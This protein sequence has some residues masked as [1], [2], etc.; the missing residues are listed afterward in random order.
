MKRLACLFAFLLLCSSCDESPLA[1]G[2]VLEYRIDDQTFAVVVPK[3]GMSHS[4]VKEAAMEKAAEMAK[5]N[6]YNYIK[7]VKEE[8]VQLVRPTGTENKGQPTNLYYEMIQE[9]NFGR[10]TTQERSSYPVENLQAYRMTFKVYKDH[11]PMGSIDVCK[12]VTC[13]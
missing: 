10:D 12:K 4:E 6:D 7:V 3:Q 1:D 8:N 13:D 5:S 2:D 11:P 9:Q